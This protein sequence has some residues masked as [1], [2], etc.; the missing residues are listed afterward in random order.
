MGCFRLD[1]RL[2]KGRAGVSPERRVFFFKEG[3]M[4]DSFIFPHRIIY[5]G[6]NPFWMMIEY[7]WGRIWGQFGL[8]REV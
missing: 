7:A 3:I 4:E 6:E 8:K 5:N 2:S 1:Q